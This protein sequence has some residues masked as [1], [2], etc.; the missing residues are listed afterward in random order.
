MRLRFKDDDERIAP[1]P[2]ESKFDRNET[3]SRRVLYFDE[4]SVYSAAS[5]SSTRRDRTALSTVAEVKERKGELAF[6]NVKRRRSKS[7][8]PKGKKSISKRHFPDVLR[9]HQQEMPE[10]KNIESNSKRVKKLPRWMEKINRRMKVHKGKNIIYDGVSTDSYYVYDRIGNGEALADASYYRATTSRRQRSVS[11][12]I[13]KTSKLVRESKTSYNKGFVL[14]SH[15]SPRSKDFSFHEMKD[16][17][18]ETKELLKVKRLKNAAEL[19][20]LRAHTSR[21]VPSKTISH[22]E[23]SEISTQLPAFLRKIN[24]TRQRWPKAFAEE[25][26]VCSPEFLQ[27]VGLSDRLARLEATL[28]TIRDPF[29]FKKNA[30]SESAREKHVKLERKLKGQN[31]R[32]AWLK[33]KK[34]RKNITCETLF[35]KMDCNGN[36]SISAREFEEGLRSVGIPINASEEALQLYKM[37]D[38][39]GDHRIG[40]EEMKKVFEHN[41]AFIRKQNLIARSMKDEPIPGK[42]P[43]WSPNYVEKKKKESVHSSETI[44]GRLHKDAKT[45]RNMFGKKKEGINEY[46]IFL[47]QLTED[48]DALS[49][50][51]KLKRVMKANR[52]SFETIFYLSDISGDAMVTQSEFLSGLRMA[53]LFFSDVEAVN[54]FN[55]LDV[56]GN[57]K[58][59]MTELRAALEFDIEAN[60]S[61]KVL[62]EIFEVEEREAL[63]EAKAKEARDKH[64]DEKRVRESKRK[65]KEKRRRAARKRKELQQRRSKL[66]NSKYLLGNLQR[67]RVKKRRPPPAPP[68][69]RF[70]VGDIVQGKLYG[71]RWTTGEVVK[72]SW[73][74]DNSTGKRRDHY[75]IRYDVTVQDDESLNELLE[76]TTEVRSP[77]AGAAVVAAEAAEAA[78]EFAQLAERALPDNSQLLLG[79]IEELNVAF[80][81]GSINEEEYNQK[82]NEVHLKYK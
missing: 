14:P 51:R 18:D 63:E 22:Q 11:S 38:V 25:T 54:L 74:V 61:E 24:V 21:I 77:A 10:N 62:E 3:S 66:Q 41:S 44:A 65:Q 50:I 70:E 16:F 75:Q 26:K 9:V 79:A 20:L 55:A 56:D 32:I 1:V 52:V 7:H 29:F 33:R 42:V 43:V 36:N 46:D 12:P 8:S 2:V 30:K 58:L 73:I 17:S 45:S 4:A 69:T 78:E 19:G 68:L 35:T 71:M 37:F 57:R 23:T 53:R 49:R 39:D 13:K 48:A 47:S 34:K 82:W 28:V 64:A 72:A 6:P 40:Y 27:S 76:W 80:T 5:R 60:V 81:L 31:I 59:T 67:Q 15:E